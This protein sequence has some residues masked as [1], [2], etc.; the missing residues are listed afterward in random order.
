[1]VL[2]L[3]HCEEHLPVMFRAQQEPETDWSGFFMDESIIKDL[4][5]YL[6]V[7]PWWLHGQSFYKFVYFRIGW[8]ADTA[9]KQMGS[10]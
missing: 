9:Y 4:C 2:S 1:M 10:L 3:Q 7:Y 6:F 5:L 8:I